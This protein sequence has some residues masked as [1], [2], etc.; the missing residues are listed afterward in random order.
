LAVELLSHPWI[1]TFSH[2]TCFHFARFNNSNPASLQFSERHS[3]MFR[4]IITLL[5]V[6]ILLGTGGFSVLAYRPALPAITT[7]ATF[8]PELIARG[9][10]LAG[11]GNCASCHSIKGSAPYAG[12]YAMK[13]G[14]G[15]IYSTNITP[16]PETG[17]GTWSEAAFQR[18][19]HEGVA[20]DG[21]HLYPVFPYDHFTK[22]SD[23]DVKALYAFVM[24]RQPAKVFNKTN[25][26]TFPLNIT[27]LQAGWKLLFFKAG[28]F[29]EQ[30]NHSA[31]WNRGAYLAEGIAHCGACHTPRNALGAEKQ[32]QAFAGGIVD[33]IPAPPLTKANPSIAPWSEEELTTYLRTGVSKMHQPAGGPMWPV[34]R[35]G[36]SKLPDSDI[37]ALAVY[38]ADVND[39]ANRQ[40]ETKS[41]LE[42]AQGLNALDAKLAVDHLDARL[43]LTACTSCHYN[44]V[45]N[46]TRTRPNLAFV[47]SVTDAEPTK[48]IS[49]ILNGRGEDMPAFGRGLS[50]TDIA[51]IA[52]YLR[53][54]RTK[55]Q[56]WTDLENKVAAV[57]AKG[58]SEPQ[59]GA[60]SP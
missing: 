35:D 58:Q 52:A 3:D 31:E 50:N 28:V 19:L 22:I 51:M 2:G 56:P 33:N 40:A 49:T 30:P 42:R 46:P 32:S 24:T 57:R 5:V 48:L 11:A 45:D 39:A 36:L 43:Y 20:E 38:I 8:T 17:I 26:L 55:S 47:D 60:P 29:V 12:G 44:T 41:A 59:S 54:T 25:E 15:T 13:T 10:I 6:V 27:A 37:H 16:D 18:A 4:R 34:I 14:F 21:T 53:A 1:A 23:D 7:I 9:E